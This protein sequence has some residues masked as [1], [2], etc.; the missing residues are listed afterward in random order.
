MLNFD[1]TSLPSTGAW[2]MFTGMMLTVVAFF[3]GKRSWQPKSNTYPAKP[4]KVKAN[5]K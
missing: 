1:V 2:M 4:I 5:D 3:M